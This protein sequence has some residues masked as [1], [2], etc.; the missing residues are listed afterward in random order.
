MSSFGLFVW[1]VGR[2]PPGRIRHFV[3]RLSVIGA[4]V[5]IGMWIGCFAIEASGY[6]LP[7]EGWISGFFGWLFIFCLI[8]GRTKPPPVNPRAATPDSPPD[9]D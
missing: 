1:A 8:Y 7:F 5:S 6:M 4:F 9:S 3:N 2:T